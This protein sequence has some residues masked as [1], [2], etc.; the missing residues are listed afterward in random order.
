MIL[1]WNAS[2]AT[3][4]H[5]LRSG[6]TSSVLAYWDDFSCHNCHKAFENITSVNP[7]LSRISRITDI[8]GTYGRDCAMGATLVGP[9]TSAW[10][11]YS[12][13]FA[14]T[15]T[16]EDTLGESGVYA[17]VSWY[18]MSSGNLSKSTVLISDWISEYTA[19][20]GLETW[21]A[22]LCNLLTHSNGPCEYNGKT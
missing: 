11:T 20:G 8:M 19:F 10:I 5:L 13:V 22:K 15:M 17:G 18:G 2:N 9:K 3:V 1:T 14:C 21:L 4:R 12:V 6:G 16:D 7:P